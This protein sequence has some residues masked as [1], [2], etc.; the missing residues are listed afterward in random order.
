[1]SNRENGN[2]NPGREGRKIPLRVKRDSEMETPDYRRGYEAAFAEIHAALA[3]NEHP[4]VC[5][6][7]GACEIC[8]V[9][10]AFIGDTLR[11]LAKVMTD[12]EYE[13]MI[14]ILAR[15]GLRIRGG[16]E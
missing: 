7:S 15:I 1:M 8:G 13:G 9:I 5:G 11:T 12:E 14:E 16:Q 10:Q 2:H 4:T 3:S 6:G